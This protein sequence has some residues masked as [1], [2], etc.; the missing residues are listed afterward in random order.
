MAVS[1]TIDACMGS[2]PKRTSHT[3]PDVRAYRLARVRRQLHE[4]DCA[5]ILLYDPVNIRYATD[6]SNMQVWTGRNPS[7][8]VMVFADGRIVAWEFHGCAHLWHGLNLDLEMRGAVGWTFFSAGADAARRVDAWAAE[9][10]DVLGTRAPNER[11][12]AV[13]RLDPAGAVC[14][15]ASG[16]TLLDG[17]AMMERARA[18]K[19]PGELVLMRESLRVCESGIARMHRE[20]R[21]GMTEQD[22]WASLHHENI[23]HGGEWIETRLLASGERTNP[24]MHECSSRVLRHG[25]LLAFDT[26]M[27]G[28]N[29]YCSDLS[30]TWTVGHARPSDAQRTLYAAAHAQIHFNMALLRPGMT[31]REFSEKAW[32]IPAIYLKNRYSCV[33]HGIGMVDEYPSI[34][35]RVDWK[36][37]GYDGRFEAGM[38]LCVESYIGAEGGNQ[39][40]KL[41]QQVVLAEHGC[42]PLTTCGFETDWL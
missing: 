10:V 22:L 6:T 23:R 33:A 42:V 41:E 7:R 36:N 15:T 8:Y 4:N 28:P 13:D 21:P 2:D 3:L 38:T 17:Q 5:A 24:W 1:D 30:R 14:L 19:S 31:F 35:H 29:G 11:R 25:E 12:L 26:D 18:I 27:V 39:G 40:V 9:I 16:L 32:Q 37:G 34:A 20:L